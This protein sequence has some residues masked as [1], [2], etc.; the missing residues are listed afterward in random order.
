MPR[1]LES[2]PTKNSCEPAW[3]RTYF[4]ALVE[5][6]RDKALLEID[7]AR[8]AIENR[9]VELGHLSAGDPNEMQDLS[10]ALTYLGIL[11]M[12]IGSESGNLLWD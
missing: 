9:I 4:I 7:H 11:L 12:Y 10:N 1:T 5:Q 6:D 2:A 8:I 3:Y